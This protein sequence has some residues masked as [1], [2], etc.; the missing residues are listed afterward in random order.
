MKSNKPLAKLH[1]GWRHLS[2]E[3][4]SLESWWTN[5]GARKD[6][7]HSNWHFQS[8]QFKKKCHTAFSFVYITPLL[9]WTPAVS[10]IRIDFNWHCVSY[11]TLI[12]SRMLKVVG[13]CIGDS[14]AESLQLGRTSA[15]SLYGN[16]LPIKDHMR[17]HDIRNHIRNVLRPYSDGFCLHGVTHK[18]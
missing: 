5:S 4:C 15:P 3:T 8:H 13:G 16:L 18:I 10:F 1:I 11:I 14:R 9:N 12:Y 6:Y 7:L 17:N 2:G